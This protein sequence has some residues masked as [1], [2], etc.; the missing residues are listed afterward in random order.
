MS[1]KPTKQGGVYIVTGNSLLDGDVVYLDRA[2]QLGRQLSKAA[3]WSDIEQAEAACS[4]NNN[5]ANVTAALYVIPAI[6]SRD[7]V[8]PDSLKEQIRANGPTISFTASCK[9]V[10]A[11]GLS[12]VYL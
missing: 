7:G 2:G 6:L 3:F 5:R 4:E 10:T 8:Y 1:G 12:D 9:P 11:K